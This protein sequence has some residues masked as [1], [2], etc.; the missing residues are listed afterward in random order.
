MKQAPLRELI[1]RHSEPVTES[2]CWIW[3][4]CLHDAGYGIIKVKGRKVRAHRV[5]YEAFIGPIPEGLF[6]CH[7]CD[8]REC[9]NPHHLFLAERYGVS[10]PTVRAIKYGRIWR[11]LP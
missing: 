2:G 7:R 8:V 6:A 9:V 10:I 5:A 11:S 3:M 4:R 1:E